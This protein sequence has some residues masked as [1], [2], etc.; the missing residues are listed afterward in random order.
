[1]HPTLSLGPGASPIITV[2]EMRRSRLFA[3]GR[4]WAQGAV[5]TPHVPEASVPSSR[6]VSGGRRGSIQHPVLNHPYQGIRHPSTVDTHHHTPSDPWV[7]NRFQPLSRTSSSP[8]LDALIR[9][10]HIALRTFTAKL[11]CR[12]VFF[13]HLSNRLAQTHHDIPRQS[14]RARGRCRCSEVHPIH[15][16]RRNPGPR[17]HHHLASAKPGHSV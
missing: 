9:A 5:K 1:V 10:T 17:H 2:A 3:R 7:E 6:G 15:S 12:H 4:T 14:R 8:P 13:I 11:R 16:T